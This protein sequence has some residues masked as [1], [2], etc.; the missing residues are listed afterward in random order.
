MTSR[1]KKFNPRSYLLGY[2]DA[3][4]L[5]K[6]SG[7][8]WE[9]EFDKEFKWMHTTGVYIDM[10]YKALKSFIR[11]LLFQEKARRIREMEK[12]EKNTSK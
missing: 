12:Y 7:E 2:M 3:K 8:K 11:K 1:E 5:I 9:I 10:E 6:S 4:E